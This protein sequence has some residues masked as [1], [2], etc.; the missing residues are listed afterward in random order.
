[1]FSSAGR[2]HSQVE[3]VK[4][5]IEL[6]EFDAELERFAVGHDALHSASIEFIPTHVGFIRAR[7]AFNRS[8]DEFIRDSTNSMRVRW[9]LMRAAPDSVR[10]TLDLMRPR[11]GSTEYF[12]DSRPVA[13][14][15][16]LLLLIP[17]RD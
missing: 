3:F 16:A 9:R 4:F 8:F 10:D 15:Y 12:S 14:R 6:D 13:V 11:W 2:E 5:D 1:M 17:I 7:I